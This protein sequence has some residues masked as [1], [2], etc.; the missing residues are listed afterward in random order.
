[1][2]LSKSDKKVYRK[3][4][5][6]AIEKEKTNY[7]NDVINTIDQYKNN[8]LDFKETYHQIYKKVIENDKRVARRYD[9]ISGAHY[10]DKILEFYANG[11]ISE[12]EIK[13]LSE[14]VREKLIQ[15]KKL[16]TK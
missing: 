16:Y 4:L 14:P 6:I 7:I 2:I 3:L 9:N 5:D 1:M 15:L 8:Q 13:E 10:F 11:L 12:E